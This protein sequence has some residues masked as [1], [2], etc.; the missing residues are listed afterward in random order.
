MRT[1]NHEKKEPVENLGDLT[2]DWYYA[3]AIP[4]TMISKFIIGY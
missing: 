4:N 1:R 2:I 3:F